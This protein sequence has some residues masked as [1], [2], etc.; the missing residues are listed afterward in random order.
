MNKK[1]KE[2]YVEN[3]RLLVPELLEFNSKVNKNKKATNPFLLTVPTDYESFQNK[4]MVF[5]QETNGWC[6]ECGDGGAFSNNID[7]SLG[8]YNSFYLDGGIRKYKGP[9]WNEFKR[10]KREIEKRKNSVFVYNNI[11]KIG[12]LGRGN[13]DKINE[14]Q[15]R[16]FN[17][18]NDEINLLKPDIIIFLTGPNYDFF[19]KKN[20]GAFEQTT[21]SDSIFRIVFTSK[22]QNIKCF[23]TYHPNALYHQKK[24]RIVI[25]QL[26]D[27]ILKNCK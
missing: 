3:F 27:E 25:P 9:F 14:I 8:I 1:L 10:I 22:H 26:I 16:K 20:I 11:N 4:I 13:L 21:I 17:I 2:L 23:K 12:K 7:K 18:I 19:I 6:G 5:G 15:F 24:N